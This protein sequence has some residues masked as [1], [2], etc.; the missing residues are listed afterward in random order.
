MRHKR[1]LSQYGKI[2]DVNK[3]TYRIPF[4]VAIDDLQKLDTNLSENNVMDFV[5]AN[6]EN[7]RSYAEKERQRIIANVKQYLRTKI[8]VCEDI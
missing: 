8:Y 7:F 6:I 2:R 4:P 3:L 1:V 5:E